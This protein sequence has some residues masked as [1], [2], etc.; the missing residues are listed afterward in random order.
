M[1]FKIGESGNPGGRPKGSGK[2]QKLLELIRQEYPDYHPLVKLAELAETTMYLTEEGPKEIQASAQMQF[3]CHREIAK[4]VIPRPR[5]VAAEEEDPENE[6]LN[7]TDDE[8]V[9]RITKALGTGKKG[10]AKPAPE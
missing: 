9:D 3:L 7:L 10:R 5:S 8:L 1:V 4:Y 6:L 2:A